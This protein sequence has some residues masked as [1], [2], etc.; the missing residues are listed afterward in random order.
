M[1]CT[2]SEKSRKVKHVDRLIVAPYPNLR[3]WGQGEEYCLLN[4][5]LSF[6]VCVQ[7]TLQ[8]PPKPP[9]GGEQREGKPSS[10]MGSTI[11]VEIH[12]IIPLGCLGLE[13]CFGN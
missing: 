10:K 13:P 7:S 2:D 1:L 6:W 12:K 8:I 5:N 3:G 4:T 9:K 11:K